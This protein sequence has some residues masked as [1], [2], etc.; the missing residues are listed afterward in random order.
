LVA[1][2][3][4]FTSTIA[5]PSPNC[6]YGFALQ[7]Q[8][9]VNLSPTGRGLEPSSKS[10]TSL[11]RFTKNLLSLCGIA[12]A[13]MIVI[14]VGITC[15]MIFVR[16]VLNQST[17]WQ[18]KAVIYLMVAATLIR[19]PYVQRYR[20]H[21]NVDLLPPMLAPET[22]RVLAFVVLVASIVVVAIM[23]FYGS[24]QWWV[25]F[26]CGWKSDT[27]WGVRLWYPIW[28]CLTVSGFSCCN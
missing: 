25:A 3:P 16:F 1:R 22:R 18:T 9:L 15:P 8:V 23:L 10:L 13:G 19:L 4:V 11:I 21:M 7:N 14:A 12:A 26:Q 24:E 28:R 6:G 20:G 2:A 27:V 17:I 5:N